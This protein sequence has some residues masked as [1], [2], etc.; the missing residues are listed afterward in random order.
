MFHAIAIASVLVVA[1]CGG[2]LVG[3]D[4]SVE[5]TNLLTPPPHRLPQPK[6]LIGWQFK[7]C[8]DAIIAT[9]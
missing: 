7:D 6:V 9:G 4:G 5:P 8:L 1:G 3:G 2:Q